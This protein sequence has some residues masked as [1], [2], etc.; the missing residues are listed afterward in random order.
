MTPAP[1]QACP[2]YLHAVPGTRQSAPA[3]NIVNQD[4]R[5]SFELAWASPGG[6]WAQLAVPRRGTLFGLTVTGRSAVAFGAGDPKI[7]DQAW[8]VNGREVVQ[9]LNAR[10]KAIFFHVGNP[11]ATAASGSRLIDGNDAAGVFRADFL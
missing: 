2:G 9:V 5:F 8:V 1:G 7:V 6:V 3:G 4:L 10:G 11:V